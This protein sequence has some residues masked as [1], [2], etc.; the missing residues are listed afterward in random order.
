MHEQCVSRDVNIA[1]LADA[2]CREREKSVLR[3]IY[4]ESRLAQV[5]YGRTLVRKHFPNSDK[6]V[7]AGLEKLHFTAGWLDWSFKVL[8]IC[9]VFLIQ[10]GYIEIS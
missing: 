5:R 9:T 10:M 3:V 6:S 7:Y 2:Y 4:R 1:E 8:A